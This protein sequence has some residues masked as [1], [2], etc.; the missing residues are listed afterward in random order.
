[1]QTTHSELMPLAVTSSGGGGALGPGAGS[2]L[3]S[4][5]GGLTSHSSYI[6]ETIYDETALSITDIVLSCT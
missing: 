5:D 2:L 3:R 1:M 6:Q 4:G